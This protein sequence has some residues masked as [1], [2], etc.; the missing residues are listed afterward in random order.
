M[1]RRFL[2]NLIKS[3]VNLAIVANMPKARFKIVSRY[4]PDKRGFT[5]F[6]ERLESPISSAK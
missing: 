5:I 6:G 2:V 1:C 4:V 3:A